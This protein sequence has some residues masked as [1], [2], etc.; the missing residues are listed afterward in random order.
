MKLNI[1][2]KQLA[3]VLAL[4]LSS[5]AAIAG[6]PKFYFIEVTYYNA[7][8]KAIGG[9]VLNECRNNSYYEWGT[10]NGSVRTQTIKERCNFDDPPPSSF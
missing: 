6:W 8:G 3:A 9:Y 5:I 2:P 1:G 10:K 4:S 7:A